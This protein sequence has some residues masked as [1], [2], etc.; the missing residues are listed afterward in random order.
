MLCA[1]CDASFM[2][3]CPVDFVDGFALLRSFLRRGVSRPHQRKQKRAEEEEQMRRFA[4][5]QCR[6]AE[7]IILCT[8]RISEDIV[9]DL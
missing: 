1:E 4:R 9:H 2:L 3:V 7:S 5:V 8:T 6:S